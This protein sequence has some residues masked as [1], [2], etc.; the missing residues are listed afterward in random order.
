MQK[1]L[2]V[3]LFAAKTTTTTATTTTGKRLQF[4]NVFF[5][6]NYIIAPSCTATPGSGLLYKTGATSWTPYSYSHVAATA[7][8]TLVFGFHCGGGDIN[9]L[10]EVSVVDTSAPT[11]Q[12]LNNPGF[13]NST[14]TLTGWV[15]WCTSGCVTNQECQ[16]ITGGSCHSGNCV[17]DF[18][19]NNFDYLAQSFLATIGHTYNISF[20]LQQAGGPAGK[21]YADIEDWRILSQQ[22]RRDR[23]T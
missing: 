23:Q 1:S 8:P 22:K 18:C 19:Q 6:I 3:S 7:V 10:D 21:F 13:D 17:Y 2:F 12:L 16:V 20:W 11:I 15:T 9:Y 5:S 4:W 14:S